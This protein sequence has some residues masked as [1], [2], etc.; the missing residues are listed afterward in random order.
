MNKYIYT[1]IIIIII[2]ITIAFAHV[3]TRL[4]RRFIGRRSR[5]QQYLMS[6]KLAH[7]KIGTVLSTKNLGF[8]CSW[9]HGSVSASKPGGLPSSSTKG[10]SRPLVI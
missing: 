7:N 5:T 6:T 10:D 4:G 2:I 3:Q 8:I 9:S 1:Y